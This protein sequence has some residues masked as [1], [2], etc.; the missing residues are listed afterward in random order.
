MADERALVRAMQRGEPAAFESAIRAHHR[1]LIAMATPLTGAELAKDVAQET[2]IKAF[3]AIGRF[4]GRAKLRTW[5]TRIA[6]NEAQALLRKYKRE[7]PLAGW[8]G[9]P[10]S[11]VAARFNSEGAWSSPPSQ[12]HH[13]SPEALLTEA[14]L[15]RCIDKHL[16]QL[17]GDQQSVL[18][19]RE[20]GGLP[21]DEIA[22]ALSLSEG[23][24]RVLLHRGRQRIYAMLEHFEEE[25]TC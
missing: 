23:N 13:D 6:L 11:P 18:L 22:Q 17:P 12:W 8:S 1:F 10:G 20:L 24:V 19:M 4:E 14:E 7:R 2:W 21:F 9:D 5:L 25:G 15:E 3:A 16:H